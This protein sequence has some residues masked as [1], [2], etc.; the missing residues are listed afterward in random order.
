[1]T[2]TS[3]KYLREEFKTSVSTEMVK[4]EGRVL[5]APRIN[6]GPQ[7]QPLVPRDGSWDMRN[8]SLHVGARI[9]TWALACFCERCREDQLRN[10]CKQMATVS[11]REGL[12]M[13]EQPVVVRY[14]RSSKEVRYVLFLTIVLQKRSE[15]CRIISGT[16][17]RGLLYTCNFH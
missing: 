16:K 13:V 10:F 5:P 6:L 1:M 12:R 8:K 11:S 2:R 7:D 17:L 15:Y 9:D 3:S 14:A 4:V